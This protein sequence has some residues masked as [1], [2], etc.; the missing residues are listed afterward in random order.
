M[1]SRYLGFTL[2][3]L[4]T[5]SGACRKLPTSTSGIVPASAGIPLADGFAYPIGEKSRVTQ[6]RDGDGWYNA[7]DFGENDHLAEDWNGEKGGNTDCGLPV[8]AAAKG[9]I[10]LAANVY[11]WGNVIIVRHRLSDG[12]EVETQYAHL[13]KMLKT[14]GTVERHEKIGLVGDGDGR[15]LCH[16]HFELRTS[17]CPSW[18]ATGVGYSQDHKGWTDPSDFIDR[19][20]TK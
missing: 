1:F 6:A 3:M 13:Q 11:G 12:A 4:I 19:H 10:V 15:F 17:D 5:L 14:S 16:L 20:R 9:V 7:Q 8:Y 18:G 2:L